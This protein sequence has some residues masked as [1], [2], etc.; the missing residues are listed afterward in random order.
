MNQ[1]KVVSY[2]GQLVTE[3]REVALMI[4]RSHDQLMRSV[5]TYIKYLD[6]AKMQSENFFIE[7]SYKNSQNKEMPCYLI[8]KKGCDM[9]AN[10]MTGE[11]GVLFTAEYVTRFEEMEKQQ[12]KVL[13]DKE[14][15]MAS[16]KLSI[17]HN[18]KIEKH[19]ERIS[20]LEETMRI[21]GIQERK[22]QKKGAQVVIE[23]LGGK[24]SAAYKEV[25]KKVFSSLWR[26]FKDHF[27]IPRYS[28]LPRVQFQEGMRFIG[29]WQPSTSLR[30]EIDSFNSQ[31]K[32]EVI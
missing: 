15:L 19:D 11:K 6:S 31:Q 27:S 13:S 17:E 30:I 28:E 25:S 1:L 32:L 5:R 12:P 2:N 4:D 18:E 29:M 23:S 7:S 20:H 24:D 9:V 10:K 21:D 8:T 14:Q 16:M 22:I 26:D 3:S